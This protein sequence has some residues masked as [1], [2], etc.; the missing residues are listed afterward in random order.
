M[1][2]PDPRAKEREEAAHVWFDSLTIKEKFEAL[3]GR[4]QATSDHVAGQ[5][6]GERRAWDRVIEICGDGSG[7][8]ARE[9]VAF[10]SNHPER[11][12]DVLEQTV[13]GEK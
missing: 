9:L 3:P 12:G 6:I 8:T 2:H 4:D 13:K 11:P 1:T 5:L 10:L 7:S